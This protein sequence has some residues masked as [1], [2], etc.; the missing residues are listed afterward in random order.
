MKLKILKKKSK[1]II[2]KTIKITNSLLILN[3]N[4][5][6]SKEE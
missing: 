2:D 5:D 1:I 3:N 4:I 6:I